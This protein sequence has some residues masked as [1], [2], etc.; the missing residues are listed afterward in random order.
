MKILLNTRIG[1]I[2]SLCIADMKKEEFIRIFEQN[3]NNRLS[4]VF[5]ELKCGA[6]LQVWNYELSDIYK[7]TIYLRDRNG[8]SLGYI[9]LKNI[10]TMY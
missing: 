10:Y 4:A 7:K 6:V 5:I 3:S 9:L 8:N 2:I 1:R